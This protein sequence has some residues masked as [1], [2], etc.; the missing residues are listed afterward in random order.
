MTMT[1]AERNNRL[2]SFTDTTTGKGDKYIHL[3]KATDFKSWNLHW[4]E[5]STNTVWNF[6]DSIFGTP[7]LFNFGHEFFSQCIFA[8]ESPLNPPAGITKEKDP[9]LIPDSPKVWRNHHGGFE[10]IMQKLWTLATIG[11]LLLVE[12]KTGIKAQI[13]GQGDNQVCRIAVPKKR[14]EMRKVYSNASSGY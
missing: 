9:N 5:L 1:E 2:L 4:S 10:G 12:E 13:V 14:T 3:L 11:I 7:N 6:L 8:L